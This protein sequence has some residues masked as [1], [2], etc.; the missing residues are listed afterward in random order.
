[1]NT[2][3]DECEGCMM[4]E[5]VYKCGLIQDKRSIN[6]PCRVCLIKMMCGKACKEFEEYY[7]NTEGV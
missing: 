5:A 4:E 7:L 3:K 1:M 2:N 6:C